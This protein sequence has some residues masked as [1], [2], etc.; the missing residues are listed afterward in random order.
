VNSIR[1][2]VAALPR[3][4]PG[5]SIE[6]VQETYGLASV[7]KLASN[8][9]Y[10]GPVSP[11]RD[12]L[13]Q[14]ING[15]NRYPDGS[16]ETLR[17]ALAERHDVSVDQIVVGAGGDGCIEAL[18]Q[19]TLDPGDEL[20]CGWPG[21][22]SYVIGPAKLGATV[23]RVALRDG[24]HDVE[25]MSDAVTRQ[26]KLVVICQPH[27]PT[28]T[29]NK[30]REIEEVL[31]RLAPH[32]TL[33]ID[34]AYFEYVDDPEYVDATHYVREGLPVAVIRTFSKIY[35][36]AGLRIGYLVTSAALATATRKV[37]RAFDVA[38]IAQ[39]AALAAL[40]A[41]DE[42]QRRRALNHAGRGNLERTLRDG[43]LSSSYVAAANFV[44]VKL[45]ESAATFAQ[46][47]LELGVIVRPL[48]GFGDPNAVRITVGDPQELAMLGQALSTLES[49]RSGA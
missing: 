40:R 47:L 19:A 33:V 48:A 30:R 21:F 29:M 17:H 46:Q 23:V 25:A 42:V 31:S 11:A 15:L 20:I 41:N 36:L 43:G 24:V 22:P 6:S 1:K 9:S 34:Q 26:T 5:K 2:A 10:L 44:F 14:G 35:G 13:M 4:V 32:A 49:R 18:C 37:Q 39:D 3:Y 12:V 27:N 45:N 16:A 8:E 7:A 28:G 38:S